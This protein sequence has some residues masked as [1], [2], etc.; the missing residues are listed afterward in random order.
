M[1]IIRIIQRW[2][3]DLSSSSARAAHVASGSRHRVM[4]NDVRVV[5]VQDGDGWFAQG[6]D[7]N[8]G[9]SGATIRQAQQNFEAGLSLTI[10]ANL[11]RLGNIDR[12]MRTPEPSIWI[13]LIQQ[14]GA[15]FDFSMTETHDVTDTELPYRRIH[16]IESQAKAA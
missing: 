14:S 8:Y 3:S 10:K 13:P 12:I 6:I 1:S 5:I 11:Q 2:V 4:L 7:I 16:Y 9:T 15:Q